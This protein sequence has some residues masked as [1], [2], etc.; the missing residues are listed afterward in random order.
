MEERH[1]HIVEQFTCLVY[2]DTWLYGGVFGHTNQRTLHLSAQKYILPDQQLTH[3]L[4]LRARDL[5]LASTFCLLRA[6][7]HN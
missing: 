3:W 7:D 4:T 5:L 6:P 1:F 2:K